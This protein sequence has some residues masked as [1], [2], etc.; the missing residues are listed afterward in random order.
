MFAKVFPLT[1]IYCYYKNAM[2]KTTI[3]LFIVLFCLFNASAQKESH[4]KLKIEAGILGDWYE[5]GIVFFSGPD[6]RLKWCPWI[7][8]KSR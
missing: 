2:H 3:V 4:I 6:H 1:L 5:G 8:K 7:P